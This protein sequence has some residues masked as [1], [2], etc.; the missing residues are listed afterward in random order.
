MIQPVARLPKDADVLAKEGQNEG[1]LGSFCYRC[2]RDPDK[3]HDRS[4]FCPALSKRAEGGEW[5]SFERI[6]QA[7]QRYA[8][9]PLS[10]ASAGRVE[11]PDGP[12]S[13]YHY[14]VGVGYRNKYLGRFDYPAM[15]E[16]SV[17]RE[18]PEYYD[19]NR[20]YVMQSTSDHTQF[21]MG[22]RAALR[23]AAAKVGVPFRKIAR[24]LG[25]SPDWSTEEIMRWKIGWV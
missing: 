11:E 20:G 18:A 21:F 17:W 6:R 25:V 1:L 23:G 16:F 7:L 14:V 19:P 9:S 15:P 10:V 22:W 4:F 5:I 3:A 13:T 24:D 8:P 2:G 12:L